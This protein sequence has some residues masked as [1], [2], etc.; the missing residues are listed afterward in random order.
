MKI[1]RPQH[2]ILLLKAKVA[3]EL[4]GGQCFVCERNYGKGF[5]FHHYDYVKGRKK[6]S[7]FKSTVEYHRYLLPEIVNEPWRFVLL[8]KRHHSF[9]EWLIRLKKERRYRLYQVVDRTSSS[10]L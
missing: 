6:W 1:K 10:H 2:S 7:D 9:A 5:A 8:C 4:F 3:K